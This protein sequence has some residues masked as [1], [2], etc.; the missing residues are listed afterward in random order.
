MTDDA[1]DTAQPQQAAKP[2]P[3]AAQRL[4]QEAQKLTQA[5]GIMNAGKQLGSE[6]L[7]DASIE[8]FDEQLERVREV[9][10]EEFGDQE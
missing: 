4:Q 1:Q 6:D 3:S 2:S 10:E 7:E 5:V 8:A 9:F